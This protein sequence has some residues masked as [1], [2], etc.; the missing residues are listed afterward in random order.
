L[1]LFREFYL[2]YPIVQSVIAQFGIDLPSSSSVPFTP[3]GNVNK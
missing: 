3:L 2:R 1:F